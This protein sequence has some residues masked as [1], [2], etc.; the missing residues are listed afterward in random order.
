MTEL[1]VA[2]LAEVVV[3]APVAVVAAL[4]RRVF[5]TA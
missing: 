3:A 5:A 4:N 2:V 1:L